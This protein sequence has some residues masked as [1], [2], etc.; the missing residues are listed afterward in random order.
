[1]PDHRLRFP[2]RTT[3]YGLTALVAVGL[4]DWFFYDQYLGWT[5]GWYLLLLTA[6]VQIKNRRRRHIRS[7]LLIL[8]LVGLAGALVDYPGLLEIFLAG[9][10]LIALAINDRTYG[11][12]SIRRW[13]SYFV[14]FLPRA[15]VQPL[16]D[17]IHQR[18]WQ[19][20]HGE[21]RSGFQRVAAILGWVVPILIGAL[22][23]TLFALA[24]PIISDWLG[25]I[26][27]HLG[28]WIEDWKNW[29]AVDR[30][31][32]WIVLAFA[33]WALLRVRPHGH[34]V[35]WTPV[36]KGLRQLVV[37]FAP[38]D[39]DRASR[40]AIAQTLY[41]LLDHLLTPR[42]IVRS[43]VIF[44]LLFLVQTFL[45]IRYLWLGAELPEGMTWAEY[46]HRGAYPLL[47]TAILAGLFV[48]ATFR[49]RGPA[50]K[51]TWAR[52]L[53]YLWIA[54]NGLLVA[55]SINRLGLYVN[56]YGLS[57]WRVAAAIWIVTI[58]IGLGLLLWRIFARRTNGWLVRANILVAVLIVYGCCFINIDGLIARHNVNHCREVTGEGAHLDVGYLE[59]LGAESIPALRGLLPQLK[60]GPTRHQV[61]QTL[62]RLRLNLAEKLNTWQGWSWRRH[63]IWQTDPYTFPRLHRP[64]HSPPTPTRPAP[65]HP[66]R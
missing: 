54:Q 37:T 61:V 53:V 34:L 1:M 36:R 26:S 41:R 64:G 51:S 42:L 23:V 12:W 8:G 65:P 10:G 66:V 49:P 20:R 25:Q 39:R 60:S 43:L 21:A 59:H 4:A 38:S 48:L 2:A 13:T 19:H 57:R 47:A 28:Q 33:I 16:R 15:M 58:G 7:W 5:V 30:I 32:F 6:L 9:F 46:A 35:L 63:R 55:G 17:W 31:V 3:L 14:G 29:F 44:N 24:N 11:R 56:V 22:F 18:R 45:D 50:M 62:R 52:Q 27:D 40:E